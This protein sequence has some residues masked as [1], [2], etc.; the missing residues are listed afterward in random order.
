MRNVRKWMIAMLIAATDGWMNVACAAENPPAPAS[1]MMR[2]SSAAPNTNGV[3]Q[4]K[5]VIVEAVA[6]PETKRLSDPV[7]RSG[8]NR[9]QIDNRPNRRAGDFIRRMPGVM[10]GGPPGE[11]KD[12]RLRG[13]DKEFTRVQVDGLQIPDGGEKRELQLDRLPAY[14]I[15]SATIVRNPTAEY[16]SDGL[17]GRM[18]LKT[19]PIPKEFSG[20]VRLGYGG[21]D[22]L[23]DPIW[24][25]SIMLGGRPADWF[26]LMGSFTAD[27][28]TLRKDMKELEF[29]S[30]GSL[31]KAKVEE[32]KK[33]VSSRD[34]FLDAGFFYPDGEVHVKPLLLNSEE[35][36]FKTKMERDPAKT[37][38]KDETAETESEDKQRE[39]A[40]VALQHLH[41]F[42]APV[43]LDS[44]LGYY[45]V[46]EDADKTKLAYKESASVFKLDKRTL[47]Q[48]SKEDETWNVGSKITVPFE[49]GVPQELKVGVAFRFRERFR[50]KTALEI[51]PGGAITDTTKPKDAYFLSEDYIAGFVQ[52]QIWVTDRFSVLPGVRVEHVDLTAASRDSTDADRGITDVNPSLHMLCCATDALSLRAAIS[53]AVNRPK[54][55]ELSPF[56]QEDS[57]KI[58]TG[59]PNLDPARSWNLDFGAEYSQRDLFLGVNFFQKWVKGV[60]EE[61]DTGTDVGGKDLFQVQNVG[62]GRVRGVELE[63]RV[64]FFWTDVKWL[65]G[66]TLWANETLLES[67]LKDNQGR[68]RPFKEQPGLIANVGLD[69]ELKRTGTIFTFSAS[70]ITSRQDF[71][72]ND[73]V[74]TIEAE[75]TLDLAARQRLYDGLYAFV[76]VNN[77]TGQERFENTRRANGERVEKNDSGVGTSVLFGLSYRF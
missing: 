38:D 51:K 16:E 44:V 52:D 22:G 3:T 26:G 11:N 33:G 55:D 73:D 8:T 77:L 7:P 20:D 27:E 64:G 40:G 35:D 57:T 50:D 49:A 70:H 5:P 67:K 2:G 39:T 13:L 6:S 71:A 58:T 1:G 19:R 45:S 63:Q 68:A 47:E 23:D 14:M 46:T 60:L 25:G 15:E 74:K 65:E 75:W 4:L 12:L 36:K 32:E 41:R 53:R 48:E 10:M 61:V 69:Y 56:E 42:D 17:A 24:N 72:A 30:D 59:N 31:K 62:D 54:F 34:A 28:D 66:L 21:R 9:E 18:E 37:A 76:E 29:K 43:H